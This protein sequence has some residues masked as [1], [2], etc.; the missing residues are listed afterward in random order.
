MGLRMS[1]LARWAALAALGFASVSVGAV[2]L[3]GFRGVPWGA[4]VESLGDSHLVSAQGEVRCY[5]RERENLLYGD[6]PLREV[7][8][9]FH[10]DRLVMVVVDAQVGP[11]ALRGEFESSYGPPRVSSVS[12][13]LWGDSSTRA[14]VEIDAPAAN[15]PASMRMYSNEYR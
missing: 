7:R 14:R 5:R 4:G 1:R 15:A 10:A 2:E 13:A 3:R 11:Q 12:T 8:F 9:C 6:A